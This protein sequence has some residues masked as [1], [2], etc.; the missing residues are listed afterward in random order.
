MS[1]SFE[2]FES[3]ISSPHFKEVIR[4]QKETMAKDSMA[5]KTQWPNYR[6]FFN[7][8]ELHAPNTRETLTT[9]P[10]LL[11]IAG[12]LPDNPRVVDLGMGNGQFLIDLAG[13]LN[14]KGH[15]IGV[16]ATPD[17]VKF[18]QCD[19]AGIDVVKGK[20]NDDPAIIELL[21]NAQGSIDQVFD[22][23]GPITYS[24]N[25][26]HSLIYAAILLKKGGKLSAM[27]STE[28]NNL[29]S[30]VFGDEENRAKIT[31]FFKDMAIGEIKFEF[32]AINSCVNPGNINTDLLIT[33][34][35]GNRSLNAGDY[36]DLC[37]RADKEIGAP[38]VLKKSWFSYKDFSITMRNYE[39]FTSS[40]KPAPEFDPGCSSNTYKA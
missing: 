30:T 7:I 25:P 37:K 5:P 39:P 35:K 28:G 23:Y 18:R 27:T 24:T 8:C 19:Y 36:L 1:N 29:S 32:S 4:R 15:F 20:L 22:T 6:G 14:K 10:N 17:E 33:F 21:E 13:L 26:L 31:K 16:S 38:R 40:E 2:I 3:F 12:E 9:Q 11:D 34:T